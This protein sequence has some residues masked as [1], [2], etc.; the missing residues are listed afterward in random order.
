MVNDV[1]EAKPKR[2]RAKKVVDPTRHRGGSPSA[3]ARKTGMPC[4]RC[5]QHHVLANGNPS[6]NGHKKHV[7]PYVPCPRPPVNGAAVCRAHGAGSTGRVAEKAR[8][9]VVW[10][11]TAGAVAKLM[12]ECDIPDQH[13]I[14]GLL[15][16]VRHAGAMMRL[17]SVLVGKL[18]LDPGEV[19][20]SYNDKGDVTKYT[21]G[22]DA[23][24]GLDH[25]GDGASHIL[26]IMYGQ[27]SDRYARAC[28]LALDANIDERLVR[29]AESTTEAL[30]KAVGLALDKAELDPRQA[31]AFS[32]TLAE[33]LRKLAG[34]LDIIP[35][36]KAITS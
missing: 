35:N 4:A 33:E 28:K 23:L 11:E 12:Q 13:P 14:N 19:K 17:L 10:D 16:V 20:L 27:W 30:Y 24:Y 18:E 25:S 5:H 1:N 3:R 8:L 15:E 2:K 22:E 26:V 7:R 21:V 32:T 34:P 36:R 29:N 9:R 31:A 6:C